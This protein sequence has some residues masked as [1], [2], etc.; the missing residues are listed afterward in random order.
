[1]D[2]KSIEKGC[3]GL[4]TFSAAGMSLATLAVGIGK[5]MEG[6]PDMAANI[7]AFIFFL[8]MFGFFSFATYKI[9]SKKN[10]VAGNLL[11]IER[12][13]IE[14]AH[15]KKGYVSVAELSLHTSVSID[16]ATRTLDELVLKNVA[17]TELSGSGKLVYVFDAFIGGEDVKKD[18]LEI[19]IEN[20]IA[21]TEALKKKRAEEE[22]QQIL[23][24]QQVEVG[25]DF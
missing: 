10:K 21:G 4:F 8:S 3:L 16:E 23:A 15:H 22:E 2:N 12:R 19:A 20:A 7:G 18:T 11:D 25:S 9:F 1:M 6:G 17:R 14:F 24:E 13:T 5:M